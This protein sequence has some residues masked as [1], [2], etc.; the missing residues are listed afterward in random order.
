MKIFNSKIIVLLLSLT[1]AFGICALTI[2]AQD[3]ENP[4]PDIVK[5]NVEYD[6]TFKLMVAVE[7]AS[8]PEGATV[9]V[10]VYTE[11][12]ADTTEPVDTFTL[13]RK[14]LEQFAGAYYYTGTTN[15]DV[16]A[17]ALGT[18][19]YM[20]AEYTVDGTTVYGSVVKYSIAEY[21]YEK[22]YYNDYISKTASDGQD[23]RRKTFYQGI[24]AFGA[25][26][27][28]LFLKEGE[29][30]PTYL[31]DALS[32][33]IVENGTVNGEE[34]LLCDPETSLEILCTAEKTPVGWTLTNLNS[35][36]VTEYT[37][38]ADG[39]LAIAAPTEPVKLTP[40]FTNPNAITFEYNA[41]VSESGTISVTNNPA[42][43]LTAGIVANPEDTSDSVY[44]IVGTPNSNQHFR[45]GFAT[46][47][48]TAGDTYT[49]EADMYISSY[50]ADGETKVT[51]NSNFGYIDFRSD[52]L[53]AVNLYY[54]ANSDG[55]NIKSNNGVYNNVGAMPVD[56]WFTFKMVT[57]YYENDGVVTVDTYFYVN[58]KEVGSQRGVTTFGSA[59]AISKDATALN[60]KI[61]KESTVEDTVTGTETV[62]ATYV[63]MYLDDIIFTRTDSTAE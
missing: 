47:T 22:L 21:L 34:K 20:Q 24:L 23:Y 52:N 61:N 55:I 3:T 62:V 29:V 25:G 19:L 50:L 41:T 38:D 43:G 48:N 37:A 39:K 40:V 57:K 9:T 8:V 30:A 13:T 5:Y 58:G 14:S 28:T 18:D 16:P 27:Q 17:K 53:Y 42:N 44:Q 51:A 60:I 33:V 10:K 63:N 49:F 54:N 36:E 15:Y 7:D 45:V 4:S 6:E 46:G 56:E 12:P 2:G 32:Y 26:A 35:G 31:M 1:I 59:G 11:A